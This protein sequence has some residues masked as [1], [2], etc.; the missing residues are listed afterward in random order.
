MLLYA[1]TIYGIAIW[2]PD[3]H[4]IQPEEIL[5]RSMGYNRLSCSV[6]DD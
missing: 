5:A 4:L 3:L 6:S 2:K 1:I